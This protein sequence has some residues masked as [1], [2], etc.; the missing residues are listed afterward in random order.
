MPTR[1]NRAAGALCIL[2]TLAACTRSA[3]DGSGSATVVVNSTAQQCD[4]APAS[5]HP[6]VVTFEVTNSG[7]VVTEFYVYAAGDR[8]MGEVENIAPGTARRLDVTLTE[9][10]VYQATCKP[11]TVGDGLRHE[12]TV[13]D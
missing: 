5:A 1:A 10:G 9:P 13:A 12:F 11:G 3:S 4:V 2:V 6:G 8:V 7:D